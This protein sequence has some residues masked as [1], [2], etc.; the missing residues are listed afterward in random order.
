MKDLIDEGE[1]FIKNLEPGEDV[2][3]AYG[4][5]QKRLR[6]FRDPSKGKFLEMILT[7]VSGSISGIIWDDAEETADEFSVGDVV[8]ISARVDQYRG[9]SQLIINQIE[10]MPSSSIDPARFIPSSD[11]DPHEM[12]ETFWEYLEMVT[13]P[14]LSQ[15]LLLMFEDKEFYDDYITSPAGKSVHHDHLGGLLEHSLQVVSLLI[16]TIGQFPRLNQDL[17][18]TGGLLHD[19][20]KVKEYFYAGAIGF[21]DEGRLLG[22][23]A[24]GH[25]MVSEAISEVPGFSRELALHLQHMILSHHGKFEYASPVRPKTP[26]AV[27]LHHADMISGKVDQIDSV[28]CQ[29][30][31]EGRDWSQFDR[32]LGRQIWVPENE[33]DTD[34]EFMEDDL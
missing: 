1:A 6:S 8:Y 24:I 34:L 10:R 18:V 20:G 12:E 7:D 23:I 19:V 27:A 2:N 15:L 32:I 26:E 11:Q 33:S 16:A 5:A 28:A 31:D 9:E 22:H 3:C 21:T 4:V 13:D 14:D 25:Q 30:R 29:A 17:L